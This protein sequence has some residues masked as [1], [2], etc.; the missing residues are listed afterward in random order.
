MEKDSLLFMKKGWTILM[1]LQGVSENTDTF[2]SH[3][4][5]VFITAQTLFGDRINP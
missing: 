1:K 2:L 4:A 3:P 5:V